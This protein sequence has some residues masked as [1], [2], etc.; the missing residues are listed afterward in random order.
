MVKFKR[1]I[2]SAI[3]AALAAPTHG[4]N[5]ILLPLLPSRLLGH[6]GL[7]TEVRVLIFANS[8]T[9][10]SLPSLQLRVANRANSDHFLSSF[11]QGE[12]RTKIFWEFREN[13]ASISATFHYRLCDHATAET[14]RPRFRH[15]VANVF[16]PVAGPQRG[17]V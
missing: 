2:I 11:A 13:D 1:R 14:R 12:N 3:A 17:R 5:Q 6:V 4:S 10:F 15:I 16:G 8:A 7:Q 9:K